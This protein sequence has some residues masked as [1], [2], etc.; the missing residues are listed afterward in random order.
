MTT[1]NGNIVPPS[2]T[3]TTHSQ[4]AVS[5]ATTHTKNT[6]ALC[7]HTTGEIPPPLIGSTLTRIPPSVIRLTG[8]SRRK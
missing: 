5:A 7:R 1:S 2:P 6:A 3:S 4:D 8:I